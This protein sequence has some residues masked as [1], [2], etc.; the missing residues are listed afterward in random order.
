MNTMA[1]LNVL[2]RG[3]HEGPPVLFKLILLVT[4]GLLI[5][6]IIQR[7][8]GHVP[9]GNGSPVQTLRDRFARGEIDQREFDHRLAVLKGKK[10]VPPAPAQSAAAAPP[11]ASDS[12]SEPDGSAT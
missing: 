8:N 11:A 10:D 4:I 5:T 2:A 6:K 3:G 1:A 12:M 7:R 9:G